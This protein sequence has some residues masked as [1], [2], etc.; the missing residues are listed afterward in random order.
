VLGEDIKVDSYNRLFCARF[1]NEVYVPLEAYQ[2]AAANPGV[3]IG[4]TKSFV[5]DYF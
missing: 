3:A 2:A 1:L 5:M 4:N